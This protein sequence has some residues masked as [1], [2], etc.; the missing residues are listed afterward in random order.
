MR[1]NIFAVFVSVSLCTTVLFAQTSNTAKAV[2]DR[3]VTASTQGEKSLTAIIADVENAAETAS[4][5]SDRRSL[6]TF[7]GS[8]REQFGNYADAARSYAIAA[9]ISAASAAGMQRISAEQLVINA[10]RCSLSAGDFVTAENYLA[11]RV[12]DSADPAISAYV[13]L[14]S[15]WSKLS[16]AET[17][18]TLD[19]PLAL[20]HAYSADPSMELVRPAILLSLWYIEGDK[21]S[22]DTLV[23]AYPLSPEAAIVL[24]KAAMLPAPFWFFS[25][26]KGV[27]ALGTGE[28][29]ASVSGKSS[30]VRLQTGLFRNEDNAKKLASEL[31]AKGFAA[32]IKQEMRSSGA[33]YYVVTVAE[34]I[35]GTMESQLKNA[36]FDCYPITQ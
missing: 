24:G 12:R 4:D 29:V 7:L 17:A 11:S 2:V 26:R 14:Y 8:L 6:Y 5:A 3:A 20:L 25:P 32:T 31:A 16:Q 36:G 21:N 13:K 1:R 22:A 33:A 27:T 15:A 23:A 9:G 28:T 19:T 34:N 30:T 18:D 35:A 10:V